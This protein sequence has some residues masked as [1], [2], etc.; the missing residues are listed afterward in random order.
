MAYTMNTKT[1]KIST[2]LGS[3][4]LWNPK[5]SPDGKK[6][7]AQTSPLDALKIYDIASQEWSEL[8]RLPAGETTGF[9]QW[10]NDGKLVYYSTWGT[11]TR[12]YSIRISDRKTEMLADLSGIP[13]TGVNNRHW[14]SISPDG[15]PLILRDLSLHEIYALDSEAP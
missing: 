11:G 14:L 13:Q 3:E 12:V 9:P 1:H 4:G 7:F 15:S 6:I 10:S 8:V 5:W 2:I